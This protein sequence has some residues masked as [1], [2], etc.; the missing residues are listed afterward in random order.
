MKPLH[1]L[2]HQKL[3]DVLVLPDSK[4]SINNDAI[5]MGSEEDFVEIMQ[6]GNKYFEG[7]DD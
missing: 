7:A 1:R 6:A 2:S 3:S 5:T 4:N